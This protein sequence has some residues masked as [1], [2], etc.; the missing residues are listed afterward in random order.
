MCAA[1]I[2]LTSLEPSPIAT[3]FLSGFLSRIIFTIS[4]FYFGLTRQARTTLAPS[5]RSMKIFTISS[6]AWIVAKV[7]PATITALSLIIFDKAW[8]ASAS[9]IS[10]LTLFGLIYCKVNIFI[11][12]WS[13]WQEVPILIAVSTLSPVS[14]QSCTPARL[15]SKMVFPTSS[16]SLSSIAVDPIRSK[17]TSSSSATLLIAAS[18][19]T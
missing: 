4:A 12:S 8:F 2:I 13:N 19:L 5:Q 11:E 16:W 10:I 17:S 7:S 18:L 1:V 14:T 6:S 15:M 9:Y 3:V